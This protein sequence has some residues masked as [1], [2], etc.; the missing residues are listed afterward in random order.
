MGLVLLLYIKG[1]PQE[2]L[3]IHATYVGRVSSKGRGGA[4][5]ERWRLLATELSRMPRLL[6]ALMGWDVPSCR[7]AAP[8][9]EVNT[10]DAP[11]VE[12]AKRPPGARPVLPRAVGVLRPGRGPQVQGHVPFVLTMAFPRRDRYLHAEYQRGPGKPGRAH[13][14]LL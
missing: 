13:V 8:V 3:C 7:S 4:E 12:H 2:S 1:I 10:P 9:G 14:P 6:L 11:Q 5:R